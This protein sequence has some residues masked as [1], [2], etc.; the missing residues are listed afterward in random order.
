MNCAT[1]GVNPRRLIVSQTLDY[2]TRT[3]Q[4]HRPSYRPAAAF[5]RIMT[6][7]DADLF[8]QYIR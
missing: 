7:H 1:P 4:G 3:M 8:E 2:E 6:D 5:C